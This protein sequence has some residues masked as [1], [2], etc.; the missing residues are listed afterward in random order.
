MSDSVYLSGFMVILSAPQRRTSRSQGRTVKSWTPGPNAIGLRPWMAACKAGE[1]GSAAFFGADFWRA[2]RSTCG[3]VPVGTS[4]MIA[5]CG[6]STQ[7]EPGPSAPGAWTTPSGLGGPPA[8][9]SGRHAV[10]ADRAG[11]RRRSRGPAAPRGVEAGWAGL[12]PLRCPW[13]LPDPR[14][15]IRTITGRRRHAAAGLGQA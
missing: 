10:A 4:C 6:M 1:G 9:R 5:V 11:R 2:V 7:S 8:E 12:R 15:T 3:Q 13:R 14:R